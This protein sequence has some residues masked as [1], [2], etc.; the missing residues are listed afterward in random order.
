V[1]AA[2]NRG[3]AR[4]RELTQERGNQFIPTLSEAEGARLADYVERFNARDFD[5]VR[6]MLAEDVRLDLIGRNR[7]I[8]KQEVSRYFGNYSQIH[9]WVLVPGWVDGHPAIIVHDPDDSFA[10]AK[11]FIVV[12]W[13][14]DA[15][16]H[17]RDFRHARYAIE[18]AEIV[19]L[20]S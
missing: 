8:G 2:L 1:K 12:Q 18:G 19:R 17:I 13:N 3:R 5:A 9:D 11:Y 10:S 20:V 14:G 7:M 6:D 4:L 15:V 16:T